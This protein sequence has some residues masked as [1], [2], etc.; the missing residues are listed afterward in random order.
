MRRVEERGGEGDRRKEE[1]EEEEEEEK[2]GGEKRKRTTKLPQGSLRK[3]LWNRLREAFG[4]LLAG[5]LS[6]QTAFGNPPAATPL[7]GLWRASGEP[8]GSLWE[9]SGKPPEAFGKPPGTSGKPLG[10]RPQ[11]HHRPPTMLHPAL[12]ARTPGNTW[13]GHRK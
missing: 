7:G 4:K 10:G 2:R 13:Q 6:L 1:E 8:Q 12:P 9:A 3:S 5:S 11:K